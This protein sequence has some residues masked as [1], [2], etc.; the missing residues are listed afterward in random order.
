MDNEKFGKFIKELRKEHNLTQKE[1]ADKINITDKAVSKWERGLSFPDITMLGLIANELNVTVEELLNGEKSNNKDNKEK[2]DVEEA[3]KQALE[4][5]KNKQEKRKKMIKKAKK[6]TKIVL[7]ILVVIG[8]I[9]QLGYLYISKEYNFEY[10]IDSL[11]YIINEI[12]L[13]SALVII[14]LFKDKKILKIV[15]TIFLG[16][17]MIINLAILF[18]NG[19]EKQSIV[20]F[21]SDLSNGLVIK[22]DKSTNQVTLYNNV[23]ALFARPM[24][25]LSEPVKD[26]KYDWMRNDVCALTYLTNNN[27]LREYVISLDESTYKT[28]Y[29]PLKKALWGDWQNVK[30]TQVT[31]KVYAD[32]KNIRIKKNGEEY[33]FEYDDCKQVREN[34]LILYKD[35]VPKFIITLSE[36]AVIDDETG[37][38]KDKGT[39]YLK[40]IS[41]NKEIKEELYCMT[42]KDDDLTDYNYVNLAKGDFEVRNGILYVSLDGKKTLE[43]PGDFTEMEDSYKDGNYLISGEKIAFYYNENGSRYLVY[44]NNKGNSWNNIQISNYGSIKIIDFPSQNVGY[45]LQFLDL[46]MSSAVGNILKTTDGGTTWK[47]VN[48][49]IDNGYDKTYK[50]GSKI[51]FTSDNVGFLTMPDVNGD[52]C[53]LYIT[54]DGGVNFE[55][56]N[57]ATNPECDYYHLP[58]VNEEGQIELNITK[59]Y[60]SDESRYKTMQVFISSDGGNTWVLQENS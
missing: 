35:N 55:K 23:V 59:G 9:I 32:S 24:E 39:I 1:L 56:M 51:K 40:E 33:K 18:R 45:I 57:I 12:I 8:F 7:I 30:Q 34:S 26:I 20:T 3:V 58:T 5:V 38:I 25:Q 22:K 53:D 21:S 19:F 43:V 27:E 10:I 47:V 44:S 31:T 15:M 13:I 2:I 28:S 48:E 50:E 36:N 6:I 52:V 60:A 29:R 41:M 4:K 42:P 14:W 16:I 46:A 37:I 49:G 54:K 17:I 11:F